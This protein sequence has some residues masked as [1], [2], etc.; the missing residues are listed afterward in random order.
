MKTSAS[1]AYAK[2]RVEN[3]TSAKAPKSN[4]SPSCAA[5]QD[6]SAVHTTIS[7]FAQNNTVQD[8]YLRGK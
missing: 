8:D 2:G 7:R 6:I 4:A 3:S 5:M 1:F